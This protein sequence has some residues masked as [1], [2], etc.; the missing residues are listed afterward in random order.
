[1]NQAGSSGIIAS[2]T[3]RIP[4]RRKKSRKYL[5]PIISMII[6]LMKSD[7]PWKGR[8]DGRDAPA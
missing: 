7:K 6:K 8:Y 3:P 2:E 4:S 1:M 5:H